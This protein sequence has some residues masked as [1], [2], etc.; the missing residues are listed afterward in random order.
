MVGNR[1]PEISAAL[2]RRTDYVR[3]M[4]RISPTRIVFDRLV[5][6]GW[7]KWPPL[8]IGDGVTHAQLINSELAGSS[9]NIAIYIDAESARNVIRNNYIHIGDNA[10]SD[11]S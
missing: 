10:R 7:G 6:H 2:S 3:V 1:N 9:E 11:R 4:R 8:Y 5:V